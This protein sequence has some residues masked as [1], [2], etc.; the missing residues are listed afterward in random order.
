MIIG[1]QKLH[2]V[3]GKGVLIDDTYDHEV[4]NKCS[5]PRTVLIV[6]IHRP[7]NLAGRIGASVI[8]FI[9]KHTYA[10]WVRKNVEGALTAN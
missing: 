1:G 4:I 6:D 9:L 10:R 7:T 5:E 3:E 2:W 8:N